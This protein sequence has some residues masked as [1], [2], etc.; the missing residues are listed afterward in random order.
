MQI[1]FTQHALARM[2]ER[3]VSR[4]EVLDTLAHPLI[5]VPADQGCFEARGWIQ[6]G[7]ARMLL[8]VV[9][10]DGVVVSVITV[11]ATTQFKRYGL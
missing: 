11:I 2:A 5:T 1:H 6:R 3:G 8:R 4:G 10:A 7:E 9:Y